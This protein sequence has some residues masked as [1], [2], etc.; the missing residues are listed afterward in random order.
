M[1]GRMRRPGR[2][3]ALAAIGALAALPGVARALDPEKGLADCTVDVWQARDGLA[4]TAVKAITQTP[5]GYLWVGTFGGVARYEGSRMVT[6]DR[7]ERGEQAVVDLAAL[8]PLP[9]GGLWLVPT[10]GNPLCLQA[11]HLERCP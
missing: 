7:S 11:D 2:V 9:G 8:V 1:A 4:G 5:D 6:F 10:Y 3:A